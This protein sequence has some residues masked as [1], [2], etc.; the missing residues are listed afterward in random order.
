MIFF[1]LGSIIKVIVLIILIYIVHSEKFFSA[2]L[3]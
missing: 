2:Y 3:T 1:V